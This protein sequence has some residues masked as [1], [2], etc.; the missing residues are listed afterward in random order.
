MRD[1]QT[2]I[3]AWASGL[4]AIGFAAAALFM[5]L[6]S[7]LAT[8]DDVSEHPGRVVI[9]LMQAP[10]QHLNTE[11][12]LLILFAVLMLFSG[13]MTIIRRSAAALWLLRN[14]SLLSLLLM[15]LARF[16]LEVANE[17]PKIIY[18]LGIISM[19]ESSR[20]PFYDNQPEIGFR[21]AMIF[22][23]AAFLISAYGRAR[24]KKLLNQ[25][26]AAET[27]AAEINEAEGE[28]SC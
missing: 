17:M 11:A 13:P 6:Y 26:I 1:L 22:A 4:C 19:P 15:I 20:I 9:T 12:G 7:R 8:P 23:A 27:T 24:A 25:Q 28:S 16:M 10:L 18:T 3:A 14:I 2:N 21:L 5:P